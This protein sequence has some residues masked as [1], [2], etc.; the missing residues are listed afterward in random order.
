MSKY[1]I[2]TNL[3]VLADI[4]LPDLTAK[5]GAPVGALVARCDSVIKKLKNTR[6]DGSMLKRC[7]E[8]SAIADDVR[9]LVLEWT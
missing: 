9:H 8:A 1:L 5:T 4:T 7:S 3:R 6:T 2:R